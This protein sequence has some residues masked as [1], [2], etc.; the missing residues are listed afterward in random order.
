VALDE[1]VDILVGVV[2]DGAASRAHQESAK[3]E[4]EQQPPVRHALLRQP[5]RAQGRPQQQYGTDRLV[6]PYQAKIQRQLV[7]G[8]L[9]LVEEKGRLSQI[10][11]KCTILTPGR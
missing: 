1:F 3:N 5:Q 9:D 4:N 2:V 10:V 11:C 7:H 8:R 6:Q